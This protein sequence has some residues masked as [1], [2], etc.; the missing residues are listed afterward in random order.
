VASTRDVSLTH[1]RRCLDSVFVTAVKQAKY[2]ISMPDVVIFL[3]T[4]DAPCR[5]RFLSNTQIDYAFDTF[6]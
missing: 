6:L 1:F 4:D 5:C 3:C 2:E